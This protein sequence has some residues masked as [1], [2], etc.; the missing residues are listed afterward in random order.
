MKNLKKLSLQKE[1]K[2]EAEQIEKEVSS[3]A[4]LDDL[5][6]SD[7]METSLFN[8]IQE[9]E[10][11][12]R[13]K[14]VYHRKKKRHYLIIALAAVLVIV[15]GSAMTGVGSKSYWKVVWDRLAGDG[16]ASITN[17]E[18]M[19]KQETED[20]DEMGVYR[21]IHEKFGID[22][23]RLRY[24]PSGTILN[25]YMIDENQRR[26]FLFYQYNG[27][28]IRYTIYMNDTDSSFTQKD[29]DSLVDKYYIKNEQF[30]VQVEEYEIKNSSNKRYVAEFEYQGIQYQL[31]GIVEKEEFDK[32]V[33]NLFVVK[34]A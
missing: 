14:V 20:I 5:K 25:R 29:V 15:A 2:K 12:K 17:V 8:K 3:H 1:V 31:K 33:K 16:T 10:Y 24:K 21:E 4:E 11:D 28:I 26:A 22:S 27:E 9:Y 32:M 30:V 6:V 18:D 34:K 19:E 23:V 7:E 13:F